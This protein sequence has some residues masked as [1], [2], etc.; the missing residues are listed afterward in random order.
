MRFAEIIAQAAT[1]EGYTMGLGS[2]GQKEV[3]FGHRYKQSNL[4]FPTLRT[5]G[6]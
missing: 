1:K 6:V 2:S 5:L 4:C 3:I